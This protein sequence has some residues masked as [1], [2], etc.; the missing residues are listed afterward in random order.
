MPRLCRWCVSQ[1]TFRRQIGFLSPTANTFP[2]GF[3]NF[4]GK[5]I[6]LQTR[7]SGQATANTSPRAL[8]DNAYS[9][10]RRIVLSYATSF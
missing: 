5:K 9:H 2:K 4:Y 6:A 3:H 10:Y 8:G 7:N 1:E